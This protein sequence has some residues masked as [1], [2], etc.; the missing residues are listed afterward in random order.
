AEA[1]DLRVL[2]S[3][4]LAAMNAKDEVAAARWMRATIAAED[5]A[6]GGRRN[7]AV[8]TS[9]FPRTLIALEAWDELEA[10]LQ[11]LAAED[12]PACRSAAAT[13]GVVVAIHR[14]E[15]D[16]AQARV[17]ALRGAP[18]AYPDHQA[19]AVLVQ[20]ALLVSRGEFDAGAREVREF[21][22]KDTAAGGSATDRNQRRYLT[23]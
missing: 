4:C 21:L 11:S 5:R 19:W 2:H 17:D 23:A 12:D 13:F 6:A 20:L 10:H 14:G 9:W 1:P 8:R 15:L 16:D 3:I 18:E 22:A 7:L